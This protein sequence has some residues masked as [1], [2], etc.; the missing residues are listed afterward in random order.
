MNLTSESV[1]TP[2]IFLTMHIYMCVMLFSLTVNLD[3]DI[4]R[5]I[6]VLLV[7]IK[8]GVLCQKMATEK[9]QLVTQIV[10]YCE[11]QIFFFFFFALASED[12]DCSYCPQVAEMVNTETT[13]CGSY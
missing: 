1:P 6:R 4:I 13:N 11:Q 3:G 12:V 9:L 2:Q 10:Y 8:N 7:D 5:P